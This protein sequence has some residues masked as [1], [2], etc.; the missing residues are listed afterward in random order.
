M[1]GGVGDTTNSTRSLSDD[2]EK[3]DFEREYGSTDSG[4]LTARERFSYWCFDLLFLICSDTTK[5]D[6]HPLFLRSWHM[7]D[8]R[9]P[10]AKRDLGDGWLLSAYRGSS[11]DVGPRWS[12]MSPTNHC[13]ITYHFRGTG[14]VDW[15]YPILML[16]GEYVHSAREDELLY[17]LRKLLELRLW[18]GTLWSAFAGDRSERCDALPG[19]HSYILFPFSPT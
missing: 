1:T 6:H 10:Q 4:P 8:D 5:G 3:I 17:V 18:P 19:L 14:F 7:I 13:E 2:Y 12:G 15:W 11:R 9:L 16:M